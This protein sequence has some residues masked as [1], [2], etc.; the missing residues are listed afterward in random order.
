MLL[1][2]LTL[3]LT[4]A[5]AVLLLDP[6]TLRIPA[7]QIPN[8]STP[9][10]S[11]SLQ[12]SFV[13]TAPSGKVVNVLPFFTQ[14]FT[15]TQ[16][17]NGAEVLTSASAPYFAVR[18]AP[19]E[20]GVHTYLQA[21]SVPTGL[22]PLAGNFSCA[23]GPA[24]P[25]DNF[26]AVRNRRFTLDNA[27]SFFLVGENMAWPGCWPY[28]PGSAAFDNATGASYMYD[29]FLPK[30]A[31]VGGNWIRLWV[32]PSLVRDVAY[33]GQE[34]SFLALALAGKSAWGQYSLEAAWRIEHVVELA[35]ALG[36]K[37]SLVLESQQCFGHGGSWGFWDACVFNAQNGGPLATG[38][39]PFTNPAAMA[40]LRQRWHYILSRWAYSTSIFSF[41]LQNEADDAQWPGGYSAAALN[42]S[43]DFTALLQANDPYGHLIDN[44]YGG[45]G[46]ASGPIHTFEALPSTSF[47]S[48]HAYNMA[49]VAQA[50]WDTVTPHA[51][52]LDKPCFLE[53]F[54]TDW[55]GPYQHR[56][57][58]HGVGMHTGAW[59]SLVGAGAGT[60]MQWFWAEVDT[61]DTYHRLAG[62]A[63]LSRA[64]ARQL[65]V[66]SWSI[67]D[68]AVAASG[69]KAGW[70]VGKDADSGELRAV[71]AW[72]YDAAYTQGACGRGQCTLGN[73]TG[74]TL[75]LLGLPLP[76]PGAVPILKW[77]NTST[78]LFFS[79]TECREAAAALASA[80][81]QARERGVGAVDLTLPFTTQFSQDAALWVQW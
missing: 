30:L 16:D 66:Y 73:H 68:G 46:P 13:F 35:R 7:Q 9:F 53:E 76:A 1:T 74:V 31:A 79:G 21:F 17:A 25:G 70:T 63:T 45:V 75:S 8:A 41:E 51:A 2:L 72:A 58:P 77:V 5:A 56:D 34:G 3:L 59:A 67:W 48:V 14:D 18:L 28:F 57:D 64:V 80:A 26:V 52:L 6:F 47:T 24:R 60:G 39:S 54:G 40:E 11:S 62:A 71:I 38:E 42:A 55:Q 10:N 65:L 44:S 23:G 37:I 50:V 19:R 32:G 12:T 49:D 36:I 29:R 43:L 69:V 15:R 61:L 20:E 22:A 81:T 27:T 78:G 4:P 33:E